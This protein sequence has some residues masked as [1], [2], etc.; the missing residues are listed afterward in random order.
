MGADKAGM[1]GGRWTKSEGV[2]GVVVVLE[3]G[4]GRPGRVWISRR[5]RSAY[6]MPIDGS[7]GGG[8]GLVQLPELEMWVGQDVAGGG[9][10]LFFCMLHYIV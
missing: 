6:I 8:V 7:E 9:F 2:G 1:N 4:L 3:H 10:F 5:V